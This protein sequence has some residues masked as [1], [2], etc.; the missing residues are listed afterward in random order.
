MREL[1]GLDPKLRR[2]IIAL[3]E[4]IEKNARESA[5]K[6]D[7]DEL[8]EIVAQLGRSV[9]ELAQ[10][11][12]RTEERV[13]E[14]A[15]AQKRTEEELRKLISEHKI[16][17]E[18]LG[19]LQDTV[20]HGLEDRIMPYIP[21]FARK[22]YGIEVTVIDRR[23]IIYPTGRYDE[24][25]IYVEG[26]KDNEKVYLIGECKSKPGKKG[27]DKFVSVLKRL[28]SHL[29]GKIYPFIV[30]YTFDPQTERYIRERYPE[31]NLLKSFEFE[32]KYSK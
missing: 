8:K 14:L 16:T 5:K 1:E 30:G 22:V 7:F 23:N 2:I 25:N 13:E 20:G 31:I 11:Q 19:N 12:K 28:K 9:E 4:E 27:I 18:L 26:L 29:D 15:Q 24:V 32:L 10:A 3:L 21:S 17:R 6:S